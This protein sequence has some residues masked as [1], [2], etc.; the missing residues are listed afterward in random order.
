MAMYV[1]NEPHFWALVRKSASPTWADAGI[2]YASFYHLF[3]KGFDIKVCVESMKVAGADHNFL[4]L[5]GAG[6]KAGWD[7]FI[8]QHQQ[9]MAA[10][11]PQAAVE[12]ETK[13]RA[14][15]EA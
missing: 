12:T 8:Q 5:L 10:A 7:A 15:L 1:D 9:Q 4:Y 14:A 6:L 2:A 3:F 13:G 11:V